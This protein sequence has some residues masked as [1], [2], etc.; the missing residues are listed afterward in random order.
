MSAPRTKRAERAPF[1]AEVVASRLKVGQRTV[2]HGH[3]GTVASITPYVGV[4]GVQRCQVTFDGYGSG[5]G[6]VWALDVRDVVAA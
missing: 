5:G 6:W 3:Y 1:N 2:V 4:D